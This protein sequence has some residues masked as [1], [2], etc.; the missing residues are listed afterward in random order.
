MR[1]FVSLG[2]FIVDE[3]RYLDDDG[4]PVS[5]GEV[6]GDQVGTIDF[7]EFPDIHSQ[8]IKLNFPS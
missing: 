7:S 3:F 2:M 5:Q 1:K 8:V 6:Q 4:N